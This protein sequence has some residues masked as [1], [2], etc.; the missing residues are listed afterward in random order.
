MPNSWCRYCTSAASTQAPTGYAGSGSPIDNGSEVMNTE[1][2]RNMI[3][4]SNSATAKQGSN[5]SSDNNDKGS[6]TNPAAYKD[7]A[8]ST[9]AVRSFH[10]SAFHSVQVRASSQQTMQEKIDGM[11]A[12]AEGQTRGIQ[13]QYQVQHHH[14]HY[15]H[16]HHHVHSMQKQQQ[17]QQTSE[18]DDLSQK[19]IAAAAQ[20]SGS[21]N[22][23]AGSIEGN[24]ANYSLHG[25]NS[26]SNHGSKVQNGSCAA[27]NIGA[28]METAN[29][30]A[31]KCRVAG[32]NVSGSSRV[33]QNRPPQRLAVLNKFRQKRKERNFGKKVHNF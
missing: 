5:G 23:F 13:C 29:G 32:G 1:S 30:T 16:H 7:R 10:P 14:H 20:Y 3:A 11:E 21:S 4:I 9:Q 22:V 15:H 18:H 25:S 28:N 33:D 8:A 24:A 2:T 17:L 26:G 12:T 27:I 31:E 6:T 19:N